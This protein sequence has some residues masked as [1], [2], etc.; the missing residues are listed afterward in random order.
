MSA[1][2]ICCMFIIFAWS[3]TNNYCWSRQAVDRFQQMDFSIF[4]EGLKKYSIATLFLGSMEP[5]LW[6]EQINSNSVPQSES[7]LLIHHI[8]TAHGLWC[9][10]FLVVF[11]FLWASTVVLMLRQCG[12]ASSV[13]RWF[14]MSNIVTYFSHGFS[15]CSF[16]WEKELWLT[17]EQHIWETNRLLKSSFMKLCVKLAQRH[18]AHQLR[19]C[20]H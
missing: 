8:T 13:R 17:R 15:K 9:L 19:K 3:S 12:G 4:T 18:T 11:F 5:S 10:G 6:R 1:P 16:A 2:E 20:S 7:L 14:I